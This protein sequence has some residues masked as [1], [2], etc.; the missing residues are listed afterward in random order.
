MAGPA[1]FFSTLAQVSAT[2]AGLFAAFSVG[3]HQL[4]RR[5]REDRTD[6]LR[7][8]LIDFR[9]EYFNVVRSMSFVAGNG[10]VTTKNYLKSFQLETDELREAINNDPDQRGSDAPIIWAHLHR[11]QELLEETNPKN[12]Y[13]LS[14][15]Q[16]ETL[17]ESLNWLYH[18]FDAHNENNKQFYFEL[19][20]LV[21]EDRIPEDFYR[22]DVYDSGGGAVN[23]EDDI[24]NWIIYESDGR[25]RTWAGYP[26]NDSGITGKNLFSFATALEYIHQ[27]FEGVKSRRGGTLLDWNPRI[28]KIIF[29]ICSMTLVGVFVPLVLLLTPS[30]MF[31]YLILDGNQL[32][33]VQWAT[34]VLTGVSF[35]YL[36]YQMVK[37]IQT[38]ISVR[39]RTS[40]GTAFPFVGV[41]R[42]VGRWYRRL[43]SSED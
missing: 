3:Q 19:S 38:D 1:W 11:I 4:E 26:P 13:L 23:P 36:L 24:K 27:D 10:G 22:D 30:S 8:A 6:R 15:E 31:E 33:A 35:T 16:L 18:Y 17:D 40:L 39:D 37:S 7:R 9:N 41:S 5:R 21:T 25:H 14:P 34:V 20:N 2:I 32:L 28:M 42:R 43:R 29:G 12:D